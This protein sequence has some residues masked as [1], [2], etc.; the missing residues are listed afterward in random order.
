MTIVI[1]TTDYKAEYDTAILE[2][3]LSGTT[4]K[5]KTT[6]FVFSS[7]LLVIATYGLQIRQI[8]G[9]AIDLPQNSPDLI[10]GMLALSTAYLLVQFLFGFLQ[11]YFRWRLKRAKANVSHSGK[12]LENMSEAVK[13]VLE[14]QKGCDGIPLANLQS[15]FDYLVQQLERSVNEVRAV[16]RG[17]MALVALQ[18][19]RFWGLDL[20]APCV[21]SV[22][23]LWLS[24]PAAWIM[25][26]TV[27][28]SIR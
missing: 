23:A 18:S 19:I 1:D 10:N 8:P 13:R 28:R 16:K 12:L 24:W 15:S 21:L 4:L 11:D 26:H 20:L 6:L 27:A 25:L 22:T 5:T 17:S 9:L 14:S 2:D 3:A 7:I